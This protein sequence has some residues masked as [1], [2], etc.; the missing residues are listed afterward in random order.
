[1]LL[2]TPVL[3]D[4]VSSTQQSVKISYWLVGAGG[5]DGITFRVGK[6]VDIGHRLEELSNSTHEA[7]LRRTESNPHSDGL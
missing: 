4:I 2:L 6:R 7:V 5:G 1:M 3:S